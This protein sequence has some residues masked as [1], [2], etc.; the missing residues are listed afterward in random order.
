MQIG[1]DCQLWHKQA[2]SKKIDILEVAQ[3]T[4]KQTPEKT[5]PSYFIC[6]KKISWK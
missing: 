4:R 2:R 3:I 1:I 6:D 5:V